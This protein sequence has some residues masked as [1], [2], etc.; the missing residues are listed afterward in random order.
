MWLHLYK[1]AEERRAAAGICEMK[2]ALA[3]AEEEDEMAEAACFS[4]GLEVDVAIDVWPWLKTKCNEVAAGVGE[5]LWQSGPNV[6]S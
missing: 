4:S 5:K 2:I 6:T 1:W 3:L